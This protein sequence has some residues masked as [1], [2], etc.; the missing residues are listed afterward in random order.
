MQHAGGLK[1]GGFGQT[2][3]AFWEILQ[4]LKECNTF[5]THFATRLQHVLVE[6][7]KPLPHVCNTFFEALQHVSNTL[8]T[9]LQHTSENAATH[10]AV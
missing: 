3:V 10:F 9:R 5:A 4:N 8:A 2:N 6:F 1:K 7:F